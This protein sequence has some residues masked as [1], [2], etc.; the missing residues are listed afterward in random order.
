MVTPMYLGKGGTPATPLDPTT[1]PRRRTNARE[2][3]D[4]QVGNRHLPPTCPRQPQSQVD[5]F[6]EGRRELTVDTSNLAPS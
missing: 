2:V 4:A 1:T 6:K 3:L 5:L